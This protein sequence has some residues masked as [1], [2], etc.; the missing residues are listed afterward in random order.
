[1]ARDIRT[2]TRTT[3]SNSTITSTLKDD[4]STAAGCWIYTGCYGSDEVNK[5]HRREP[6][7]PYGHGWGFAWP[8]DRRIIYN[9]A[10]ARPDGKPWSERKKLVWWDEAKGEWTGD[11]V[12]DFPKTKAPTLP[13][14]ARCEGSRRHRG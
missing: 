5:C 14:A 12:P 2:A 7:G 10:S 3:A 13:A 9:R 8:S 4:G 6:H 1:M 11:D